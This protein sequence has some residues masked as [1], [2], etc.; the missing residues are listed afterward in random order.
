LKQRLELLE[1]FIDQE[2]ST[3]S[4][5]F[6]AGGVTIIDLSCPFVDANTA[7]MLFQIG[8]S[9]YLDSNSTTGKVIV[10]D[11]AHKVP[12]FSSSLLSSGC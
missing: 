2:G 12:F 3:S 6:E 1:S 9:M 4:L 7:C 5:C 11:E 10:V 8:I